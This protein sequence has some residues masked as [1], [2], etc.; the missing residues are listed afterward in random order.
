[1]ADAKFNPK[2][3][4]VLAEPGPW[5]DAFQALRRIV[6][7]CG[8]TEELKWGQ[9]CFTLGGRNVVLIHGFKDYCALLFMKGALM[10]DP[11]GLLVQQSANVQSARQIRFKTLQEIR[12]LEPRVTAAVLDAIEVERSGRSVVKKT[13]ADFIVADEFQAVLRQDGDLKA[14]FERLTPGRQR[15]Y[16]LYFA[17]AKQAQTRLARIAKC[18]PAI[19]Q[20]KGLDDR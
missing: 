3:D 20:G 16:L 12:D 15:G 18:A 14:A 7:A 2:V 1:M 17:A 10:Q 5:T 4:A 19:L 13:T 6:L 8:L 11:G 9:P